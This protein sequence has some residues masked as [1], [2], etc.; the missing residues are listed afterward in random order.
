[1]F[2]RA[3]IAGCHAKS[4]LPYSGILRWQHH[5][6]APPF[7]PSNLDHRGRI[8][9]HAHVEAL[10][11]AAARTKKGRVSTHPRHID[12]VDDANETTSET[13]RD[14][15]R[16]RTAPT[17]QAVEEAPAAA[18]LGGFREVRDKS[19]N[20]QRDSNDSNGRGPS[21]VGSDSCEKAE[22]LPSSC[23]ASVPSANAGDAV[24]TTVSEA[25][26]DSDSHRSSRV[27][28][29]DGRGR[30]VA[31]PSP[32]RSLEVRRKRLL[33]LAEMVLVYESF[34]RR[35]PAITLLLNS[36]AR[37]AQRQKRS[38]KLTFEIVMLSPLPRRRAFTPG[39]V[40]KVKLWRRVEALLGVVLPRGFPES[41]HRPYAAYATWQFTSMA[42]SSA[43]GVMSTQALVRT[44]HRLVNMFWD[45]LAST[46]SVLLLPP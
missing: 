7:F 43:A 46:V 38:A 13:D 18:V 3:A 34:R 31:E 14:H 32:P 10:A 41:V 35:S 16:R 12:A 39:N 21:G 30:F 33:N 36:L 24:I 42:A 23:T 37:E 4:R 27:F 15:M 6:L 45:D 29:I 1:M 22:A 9:R 19:S 28:D 25:T 20:G 5:R 8:A 2:R 26:G 11:A 40:E 44:S 17:V